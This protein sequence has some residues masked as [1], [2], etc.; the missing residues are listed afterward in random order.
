[1]YRDRD[2]GIGNYW[3]TGILILSLSIIAF[4]AIAMILEQPHGLKLLIGVLL[5]TT[6]VPVLLG[7]LAEKTMEWL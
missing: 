6:I 7:R 1:M 2:R 5:G 4:V 3:I